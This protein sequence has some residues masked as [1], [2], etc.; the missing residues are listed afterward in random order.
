MEE[1]TIMV[2][3]HGCADC[4]CRSED[5]CTKYGIMVKNEQSYPVICTQGSKRTNH[6]AYF[7]EVTSIVPVVFG[8]TLDEIARKGDKARET[9]KCIAR[10]LIWYMLYKTGGW[11][12]TELG[13][14]F[15]RSHC[16]VLHAIKV[17]DNIISIQD[18]VWYPLVV[19]CFI[20]SGKSLTLARQ[21][22]KNV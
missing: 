22:T 5:F 21:L 6:D 9:H 20:Q 16:T 17:I 8:L 13:A 11:S 19:D 2:K 10:S 7:L 3:I 18:K 12:T 4:P 14:L 15:E 1:R